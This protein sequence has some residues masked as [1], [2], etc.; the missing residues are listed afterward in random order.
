MT[1]FPRIFAH[2]V[3]QLATAKAPVKFTLS[4]HDSSEL[5]FEVEIESN[6]NP[7]LGPEWDSVKLNGK[8]V[9]NRSG[10]IMEFTRQCEDFLIQNEQNFTLEGSSKE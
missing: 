1:I 8:W 6:N 10:A 4:P 9:G 3:H 7:L 2:H 5:K